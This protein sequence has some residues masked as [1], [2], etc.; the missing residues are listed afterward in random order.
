MGRRSKQTFIQRKHTDAPKAQDNMLDMP[1]YQ[2]NADYNE[3]SPHTGQNGHHQ[4]MNA[5]EGIGKREPFYIVGGD[6]N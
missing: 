3:V 5:R 6:V 4:A 1:D 2:R